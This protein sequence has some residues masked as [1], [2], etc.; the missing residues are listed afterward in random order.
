MRNPSHGT[1][2]AAVVLSLGIAAPTFAQA[3][4]R[5]WGGSYGSNNGD[6]AYRNGYQAGQREGERD[7]RDRKDYGF[8]RDDT[9][10]DADWGF[11]GGSKS[12]YKRAFRRGYE[13]GYDNGYRRYAGGWSNNGGWN[14]GGWNNGGWNNGG[15]DRRND[16]PYVNGND[17]AIYRSGYNDGYNE[18]LRDGQRNHR[19]EPTDSGRY[20]SVH[21]PDANDYRAGF[22]AGYEEGYRYGRRY[23][24]RRRW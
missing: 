1:F 14:N 3:V 10:E 6:Y 15:W 5:D 4:P 13:N 8:K 7:A 17:R 23:D 22:R 9:Y 2:W 21:G 20:R 11:R 16:G 24:D 12:D 19:F 18:G